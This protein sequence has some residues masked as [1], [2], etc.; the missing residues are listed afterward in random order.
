MLVRDLAADS[1]RGARRR[2]AGGAARLGDAA[3]LGALMAVDADG[4]LRGVVTLEQVSRALQARLT[5]HAG[6]AAPPAG[7]AERQLRWV[8]KVGVPPNVTGRSAGGRNRRC[9]CHAGTTSHSGTSPCRQSTFVAHRTHNVTAAAPPRPRVTLGTPLPYYPAAVD[10]RQASPGGASPSAR[11]PAPWPP[12]DRLEV[13]LGQAGRDPGGGGALADLVV[14]DRRAE[15]DRQPGAELE[16]HRGRLEAVEAGIRASS[17]TTSG[18]SA[19][20]PPRH[21]GR[22]G[23]AGVRHVGRGVLED[24]AH[25][26]ADIGVVVDDEHPDRAL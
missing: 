16:Q 7:A 24:R 12:G 25:Q 26:E 21:P 19:S 18:S 4:R 2:A 5:P 13:I 23:L 9:A 17:T 8:G 14:D 10:V 6:S 11:R 22:R 15:Q 3:P 20:T 1:D